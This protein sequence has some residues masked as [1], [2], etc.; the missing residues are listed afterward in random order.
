[1]HSWCS[2]RRLAAI[3]V[4]AL[5]RSAGC[6]LRLVRRGRGVDKRTENVACE[7]PHGSEVA[8]EQAAKCGAAVKPPESRAKLDEKITNRISD[9]AKLRKPDA[10]Q[11]L[12]QPI[13][14][15]RKIRIMEPTGPSIFS[16]VL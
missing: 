3:R 7:N 6:G 15:L 9:A 16:N 8:Y 2:T 4:V 14:Y 13:G 11:N 1:V 12:S 5:P 10:D